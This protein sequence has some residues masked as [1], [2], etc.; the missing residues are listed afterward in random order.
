LRRL[1]ITLLTAS[2]GLALFSNQQVAAQDDPAPAPTSAA[3]TP[4]VDVLEVSGLLDA[5]V[6]DEIIQAIDRAEADGSQALILQV[7]ST[8]ATVS[9][10]RMAE[11]ARAV[12]DA[13]IPVAVWVGPSGSKAY[14]LPGQ[15]VGVAPV[16]GMAI[17][18]KLGNFG[19]PL[20]IDGKALEFGP[21]SDRLQVEAVGAEEAKQIGALKIEINDR[22]VPVIRNM[23]LALD[24]VSYNGKVLDTV[25][26]VTNAEGAIENQATV[27][28]FFKLGLGDRLFHTVSSEPAAYL[29]FVI[30]LILLIFEFY[31]AGLGLAAVVGS[32]CVMLGTFGLSALPVRPWAVALLLVALYCLAVDVQVGIPRFWTGVGLLLFT[33][34]SLFLYGDGLGLSSFTLIVGI[35]SV[36]LAFIVGMPSMVRTRFATPTIGREWMIGELGVATA[37]LSPDGVV[38]VRDAMWRGR[39]NRSTPIAA[40]DPVRVVAIDGITLEVEPE[41]GAARDYR[42]HRPKQQASDVSA[43]DEPAGDEAQA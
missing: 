34:A 3:A 10:E 11:V 31:T 16:S 4:P 5:I 36:A 2:V 22:T 18:T 21:E 8:K 7:N 13:E 28:R 15:L 33:I 12:R 26:Q 39:T 30:G 25:T 42:E 40:G 35:A 41:T 23:V 17:G 19:V 14:G 38:R 29:L 1:A 20:T 37:D 6:A 24:G 27:P 32:V 43:L 9:R